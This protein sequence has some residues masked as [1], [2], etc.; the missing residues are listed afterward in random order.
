MVVNSSAI[1]GHAHPVGDL[2]T[3][4][5]RYGLEYY[6]RQYAWQREHVEALVGDL[7]SRFMGEWD[8]SHER[9]EGARYRQYF[10]GPIITAER[11]GVR[12]LIDGQQRMTTLSLLMLA[13]RSRTSD[14]PLRSRLLQALVSERYGERTFT[15][16]VPDRRACMEAL[17]DG[18]DY[19]AQ[20][21]ASS[22]ANLIGRAD[23]IDDLLDLP[24][25]AI[26]HFIEW[27]LDRVVLVEITT[28]E[29]RDAYEVFETMNDRGLRLTSVEMLKG[30]LLSGIEDDG[31]I[32]AADAIWIKRTNELSD[33][34]RE[35]DAVFVKAWLRAKHA[36]SIRGGGPGAA[37]MD[38]ELIG[39]A[40]HRWTRDS[41]D[42]L[43]LQSPGQFRTLLDNEFHHLSGHFLR[44]VDAGNRLR[45]GMEHIR[46]VSAF[47]TSIIYPLLLAPIAVDDDYYVADEKMELVARFLDF[48]YVGRM[49]NFRSFASRALASKTFG[50]VRDMRG[51]DLQ[52]L[53]RFLHQEA[54]EL[55]KTEP[56]SNFTNFSLHQRNGSHVFFV[57]ARLT[58]FIEQQ[59]D[60]KHRFDD[61]QGQSGTRYEVEHILANH[62]DQH[63]DEWSSDDDFVRA[64]N[65]I[66][67][68]LLLPKS[69]NASYSDDPY[70]QKVDHYFAQN[71]LA[72]SLHPNAYTRNPGFMQ[73]VNRDALPF[74]P[75][76]NFD[77]AAIDA[78]CE[79]YEQVAQEIWDVDRLFPTL[80]D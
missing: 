47:S 11:D 23:D 71:A 2:L 39:T 56:V 64:R 16:D 5:R 38:W 61:L 70:D 13:L 41:R 6:Q 9:R 74:A 34:L 75:I 20:E 62:P 4:S 48:F 18:R 30:F 65:R 22:E 67:A 1:T 28:A 19:Q 17:L 37:Q 36:E 54:T 52:A 46:F 60:G 26:P 40:P 49:V 45:K 42:A 29:T 69:F 27:L 77:E 8:P 12:Y 66:G 59:S 10:L 35:G 7:T 80:D 14:D 15:L 53:R 32:A 50:W 24:A 63:R 55:A 58:D 79:L 33:A 25:A 3:S 57:L 31:L 21:L 72:A 68:L 51:L 73:F 78:R 76:A 44:A 43:H